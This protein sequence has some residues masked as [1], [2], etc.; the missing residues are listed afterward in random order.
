MKLTKEHIIYATTRQISQ[1]CGYKSSGSGCL[2]RGVSH[3]HLEYLAKLCFNGSLDR[4]SNALKARQRYLKKNPPNK[5][6]NLYLDRK[7]VGLRLDIK[8]FLE[9]QQKQGEEA[10]CQ[11]QCNSEQ[12]PS[13][14]GVLTASVM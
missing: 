14:E 3:P 13:K 2:I 10:I 7:V 1:L 12:E 5:T 6:I 11:G 9:L 8:E 4:A